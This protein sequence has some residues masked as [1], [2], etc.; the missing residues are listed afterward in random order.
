MA[1][2]TSDPPWSHTNLV[3]NCF[4][5]DA[6]SPSCPPKEKLAVVHCLHRSS[7]PAAVTVAL[8]CRSG[9]LSKQIL[10]PM[11]AFP[12][13]PD[14]GSPLLRVMQDCRKLVLHIRRVSE[15]LPHACREILPSSQN[16]LTFLLLDWRK[17][18]FSPRS[19]A[20]SLSRIYTSKF[21][22]QLRFC[23]FGT[24]PVQQIKFWRVLG[25]VFSI[26]LNKQT[27]TY[28]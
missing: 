28:V 6:I 3:G 14:L 20:T 4:L 8:H 19:F 23:A 24:Q 26:I 17:W 22:I 16:L 18:Y 25:R 10:A 27:E 2:Q 7:D 1:R 15:S 5:P 11:L 21:T 9:R 12:W 13:K